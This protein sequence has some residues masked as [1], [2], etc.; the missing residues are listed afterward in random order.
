MDEDLGEPSKR[1][2]RACL[3]EFGILVDCGRLLFTDD[4]NKSSS[5]IS[6]VRFLGL[7]PLWRD[8]LFTPLMGSVVRTVA[9][10]LFIV[11]AGR[12]TIDTVVPP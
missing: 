8:W 4:A 11:D 9:T 7:I 6:T 2:P 3:G 10:C 5:R 12:D 1:V